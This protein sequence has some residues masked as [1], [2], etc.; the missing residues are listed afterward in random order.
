MHNHRSGTSVSSGNNLLWNP[1]IEH[2]WIPQFLSSQ[3]AWKIL[4]GKWQIKF[5]SGIVYL[6][7]P[8]VKTGENISIIGS[9]KWTDFNFQIRFKILTESAKP[10][11]GGLILYFLFK[12]INS[13]YSFH[14]CLYKQKIEL[15]KRLRGSWSTIAE[16]SYELET[17]KEYSVMINTISDTH[18][19][20][21]DGANVIQKRD[22]DISEG[23]IGLG[24]K[25]CDVEFNH[26]S[27]SLL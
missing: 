22:T 20:I 2:K 6:K 9:R 10:P 25:Y 17:Q 16:Q 15:I 21:I 13:F 27:I 23:C 24:V 26:A 18:Q 4:S 8:N 19:C 12:T 1:T 11:E 7:Q 3:Y 14:F 5:P